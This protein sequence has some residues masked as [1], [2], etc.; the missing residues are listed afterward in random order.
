MSDYLQYALQRESSYQ[1]IQRIPVTRKLDYST[2][3]LSLKLNRRWTN[4]DT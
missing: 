1:G 3:I 4:S 2:E